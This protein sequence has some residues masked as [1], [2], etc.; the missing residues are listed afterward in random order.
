MVEFRKTLYRCHCMC[1][2]AAQ[3]K[4]SCWSELVEGFFSLLGF[5]YLS[6]YLHN[7]ANQGWILLALLDNSNSLCGKMEEVEFYT[8]PIYINSGFDL[9]MTNQKIYAL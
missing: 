3:Q 9:T 1:Y 7:I 8:S 4:P 5:W 2:N 6:A